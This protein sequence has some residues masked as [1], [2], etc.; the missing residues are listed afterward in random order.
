MADCEVHERKV[1]VERIPSALVVNFP[2]VGVA[3]FF[4]LIVVDGHCKTYRDTEGEG[5]PKP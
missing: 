1:T 5:L 2:L 4:S 3:C